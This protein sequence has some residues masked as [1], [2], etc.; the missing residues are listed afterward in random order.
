M[1]FQTGDVHVQRHGGKRH[2]MGAGYV[3]V[4]R[5]GG[6]R[7][8]IGAISG[9]VWMEWKMSTRGRRLQRRLE[10]KP[11]CYGLSFKNRKVDFYLD[12]FLA[13]SLHWNKLNSEVLFYMCCC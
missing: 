7:Y 1:A 3:H 11:S 6:K 10:S 2:L 5:H 4:Q 8:L 13:A 12:L 9:L